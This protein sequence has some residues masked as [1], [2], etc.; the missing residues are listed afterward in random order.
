MTCSPSHVFAREWQHPP[1]PS[2]R[3]LSAQ[4]LIYISFHSVEPQAGQ[5]GR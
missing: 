4:V 5:K 3:L 1:K 2:V